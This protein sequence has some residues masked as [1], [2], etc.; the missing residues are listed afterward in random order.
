MRVTIQINDDSSE[1]ERTLLTLI[2][3]YH[4]FRE[5][6][7]KPAATTEERLADFSTHS[8]VISRLQQASFVTAAGNARK[9][10]KKG[11]N[12]KEL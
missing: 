4:E 10:R 8:E 3:Q 2:A 6:T 11:I 9:K 12:L 5:H 7:K 1:F